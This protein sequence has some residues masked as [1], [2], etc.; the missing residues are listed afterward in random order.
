MSGALEDL[1][2]VSVEQAV[3]AP[4]CSA[5]LR[6]A[7]ARVINRYGMASKNFANVLPW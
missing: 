1:L 4:F 7:G 3:A 2:V 6:E 5:R